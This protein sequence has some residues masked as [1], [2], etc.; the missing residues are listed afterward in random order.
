[1][2]SKESSGYAIKYTGKIG[3]VDVKKYKEIIPE[4][5]AFNNSRPNTFTETFVG[6]IKEMIESEKN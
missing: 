1:M 4:V 5:L 3:K 2:S 6:I